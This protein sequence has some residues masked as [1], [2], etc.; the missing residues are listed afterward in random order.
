[1]VEGGKL[2]G[3]S[4]EEGKGEK[5]EGRKRGDTFR[6]CYLSSAISSSISKLK[7]KK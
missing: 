1:M 4:R 5:K 6:R 3:G 2:G 7:G